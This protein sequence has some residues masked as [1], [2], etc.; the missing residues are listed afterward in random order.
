MVSHEKTGR[1]MRFLVVVFAIAAILILAGGARKSASMDSYSVN[2]AKIKAAALLYVPAARS[3]DV[4]TLAEN[5]PEFLLYAASDSELF[6][7][8]PGIFE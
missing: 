4:L 7:V 3:A 1:I 6:P 5:D 8:E 2:S